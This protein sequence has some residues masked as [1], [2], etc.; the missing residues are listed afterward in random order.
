[1]QAGSSADS[2]RSGRRWQ[3][4]ASYNAG[5]NIWIWHPERKSRNGGTVS[6]PVSEF[7]CGS[8]AAKGTQFSTLKPC[9]H[10]PTALAERREA[11]L[12]WAHVIVTVVPDVQQLI[13]QCSFRSTVLLG[14][15]SIICDS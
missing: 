1:M 3:V 10:A 4:N 12:W 11:S 15:H 13:R 5:A 7:Q 9:I 14:K 2:V 8:P 6:W